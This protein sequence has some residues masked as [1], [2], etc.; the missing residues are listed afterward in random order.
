M[1]TVKYLL[2]AAATLGLAAC[3]DNDIDIFS[4][5]VVDDPSLSGVLDG[6]TVSALAF[7]WPEVAGVHQYGYAL[8]DP[9]GNVVRQGVTDETSVSF[10]RLDASTTYVLTVEAYG[11]NGESTR[12]F[13]LTGTTGDITALSAPTN[14]AKAQANG[15]VTI[16]W[17][18]VANAS[19]YNVVLRDAEEEVILDDAV[20]EPQ[21]ILSGLALG[22][23][24]IVVNAS[25]DN[26]AFSQSG[27][28]TYIFTR[29][30]LVLET[31]VGKYTSHLLGTWECTMDF[32]DDDS[33]VLHNFMNVDGYDLVF[34]IDSD[35]GVKILNAY[36]SYTQDSQV[37]QYVYTGLAD[38]N[39]S[40]VLIQNAKYSYYSYSAKEGQSVCLSAFY[41]SQQLVGGMDYFRWDIP[42]AIPEGCKYV[43]T[44]TSSMYSDGSWGDNLLAGVETSV[45]VYDGYV[46]LRSFGGVDGYDLKVEFDADENVTAVTY[47]E[48]GVEDGTYTSGY[49]YT[50][51]GQS[52]LYCMM[53]YIGADYTYATAN[54]EGGYVLLSSYFYH[55]DGS[56][57]WGAYYIE[58][59]YS[60]E[61]GPNYTAV[62]TSTSYT[63]W[64]ENPFDGVESTVEAYD[65]YVIIRGIGGVEGYDMKIA[66]DPET[67][68]EDGDCEVSAITPIENGVAGDEVSKG[69]VNVYSGAEPYY[70]AQLYVASG[71]GY[72]HTSGQSGYIIQAGYFYDTDGDFFYGAYYISW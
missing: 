31:K 54:N 34:A 8:A 55:A 25:S 26:E 18:A 53:P 61:I 32:C 7:S 47:I 5:P 4:S 29:D 43:A 16:T 10:T 67:L 44:S 60:G 19:Q 72:V 70:V 21:I 41:P 65:N 17:D 37:F 71:Y 27:S 48:N 42:A 24:T 66:W 22:E 20:S 11:G 1:K 35:K 13:T 3:N 63:D 56:S 6:T 2:V 36:D 59:E 33:Y 62:G 52:D 14:I 58:W 12:R 51:T 45:E 68:D 28:T 49:A 39:S 40:V 30:R 9:E 69:Y 15:E 38:D 50:Y 46:I 57:E 23:Y 64:G